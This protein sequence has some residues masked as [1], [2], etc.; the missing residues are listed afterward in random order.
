[1]VELYP[2]L[3]PHHIEK[4]VADIF[5]QKDQQEIILTKHNRAAQENV[6]QIFVYYFF[7]KMDNKTR[8]VTGNGRICS[9]SKYN[10]HPKKT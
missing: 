10:R 4:M 1:M 7:S 3:K 5:D 8:K 6:K 9:K 2:K